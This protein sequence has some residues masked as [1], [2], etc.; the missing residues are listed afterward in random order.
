M[1]MTVRQFLLLKLIEECAEVAQRASKQM[2]FGAEQSQAKDYVYL[3]KT[4]EVTTEMMLTNSKRLEGEIKD[5]VGVVFL[6]QKTGELSDK[7]LDDLSSAILL[8]R[9]KIKKYMAYSQE[10][11]LVETGGLDVLG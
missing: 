9:D 6:L 8:K 2:Q 5:L 4:K 3:G 11:G 1:A 10:L 7:A